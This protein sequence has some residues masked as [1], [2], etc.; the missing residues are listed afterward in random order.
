MAAGQEAFAGS[1][2]ALIHDAILNR[3]PVATTSLNPQLPHKLEE[4]INK[5]LEKDRDLRYQTAAEIRAD[6]KRLKRD[7]E[8]GRAVA[9]LSPSPP[10]VAGAGRS[11]PEEQVG[12]ALVATPGQPQGLPLRRY[13]RALAAL[14]GNFNSPRMEE[15][16]WRRCG[17]RTGN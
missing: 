4:I 11:R 1:T 6:L 15:K 5:G 13:G 17:H 7:T 9:T 3:T 16:T 10:A 12:A 14:G 8:S 2:T